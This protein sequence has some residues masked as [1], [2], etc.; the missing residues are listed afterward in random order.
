MGCPV[1][2]SDQKKGWFKRRQPKKR[3]Y[4]TREIRERILIVCEV[5]KPSQIISRVS[6]MPCLQI[7]WKYLLWEKAIIRKA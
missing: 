3:Q 7:W 4:R 2:L 5:K 6:T 1:K